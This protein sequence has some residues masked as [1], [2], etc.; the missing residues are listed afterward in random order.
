MQKSLTSVFVSVCEH[1]FAHPPQKKNIYIYGLFNLRLLLVR[2]L[3]F[4]EAD[5]C[6]ARNKVLAGYEGDIVVD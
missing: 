3:N 1:Q 6:V 2:L 5:S 4:Y